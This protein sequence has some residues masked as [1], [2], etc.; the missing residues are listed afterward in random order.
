MS[1]KFEEKWREVLD[2]FT[3]DDNTS[4]ADVAVHLK[5]LKVNIRNGIGVC[6]QTIAAEAMLALHDVRNV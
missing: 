4:L 5:D 2:S 1:K 3:F 6:N